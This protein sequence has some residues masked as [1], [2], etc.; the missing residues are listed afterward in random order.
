[1]PAALL[2]ALACPGG[3]A[4]RA[5]HPRPRC[6]L[7]RALDEPAT[8]SNFAPIDVDAAGGVGG[9]SPQRFGPDAVLLSG[10]SPSEVARVRGLLDEIGASFV[11]T[12]VVD[13]ELWN[14]EASLGEALE[15]VQTGAV[16]AQGAPRVCVVSGMSSAEAMEVISAVEELELEG[17]ELIW[18]AAVP[19]SA[20]K[21]LRDLFAEVEGDHNSLH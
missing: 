4:R 14:G 17:G 7:L 5:A 16:C 9:T 20:G 13:E 21:R 19:K 10:C 3:A 11:R 15:R 1:M 12:V 8:P 6:L 2:A 18:A